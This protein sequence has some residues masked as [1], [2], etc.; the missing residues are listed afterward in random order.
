[1][2]AGTVLFSSR[3]PIG[4]VAIAANEIATNQG[5]KS[6]VLPSGFDPRFTYYQLKHLK[7]EAEAIATGTTFKELS[8]AAA[9]TLPFSIAPQQEQTRIADQ[10]DTLLARINACND[11]LAAIPGLIKRFRYAVLDAATSGALTHDWREQNHNVTPAVTNATGLDIE[12]MHVLPAGWRW[13]RFGAFLSSFRSGTSVVPGNAQTVFPVLRS[14]SVRPMRI[15]FEDVRYF[16]DPSNV[17]QE[18]LLVEG[19]LLFTRL[20]G[21]LEYVANCSM[22]RDLGSRRIYYP[23]RLFRAKL[24]RPEQGSYFE[25]CFASPSLRK[26]LTV[27]AKSTAG[28][29]R[30]SMGAVTNFPIPLPSAEEQKEIVHRV[31]ALFK[32]ADSIE[33]RYSAG[34]LQAQRLIPLVLAK[35]FRG[36]LVPQNPNDEPASE[37]LVKLKNAQNQKLTLRKSRVVSRNT[38]P[39]ELA[40]IGVISSKISITSAI[41]I[42]IGVGVTRIKNSGWG[43]VAEL[44]QDELRSLPDFYSKRGKSKGSTMNKS[45]LDKDVQGQPYLANHLR[46]LGKPVSAQVLFRVAELPLAD[47]YKQL[48]WEVAQGLVKDNTTTLE[49]GHAVG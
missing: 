40:N 15:D 12:E 26:H 32:R 28:H 33:V 20:S 9:A 4:Y 10:L 8:G 43:K 39:V 31:N 23:D 45:R 37:L 19:D 24:N 35:A 27:E 44:S 1:M 16:S 30:I 6:F 47:F 18:D 48:A 22:V 13:E 2:P 49:P 46:R 36:D 17:R 42:P 5:F 34:S 29:Q 11:R 14:S 21:S 41:K 25:I 7:P 3:A 38:A